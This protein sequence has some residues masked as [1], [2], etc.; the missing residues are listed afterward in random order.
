MRTIDQCHLP[1]HGWSCVQSSYSSWR[2]GLL[3]CAPALTG[4]SQESLF[5]CMDIHV[6]VVYKWMWIY[7]RKCTCRERGREGGERERERDSSEDTWYSQKFLQAVEQRKQN[8]NYKSLQWSHQN[9]FSP[10]TNVIKLQL[11]LIL[12]NNVIATCTDDRMK[13]CVTMHPASYSVSYSKIWCHS[14]RNH[15]YTG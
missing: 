15:S 3:D 4:R 1:Q 12:Q 6:H 5:D 8:K 2:V 7:N 9:N 11:V 13:Q 14:E 10:H